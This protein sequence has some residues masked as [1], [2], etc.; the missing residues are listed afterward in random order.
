MKKLSAFTLIE[1][2]V[3][4]AIIAILA[5]MLLPILARAREEA[6]RGTCSNN[7]SQI[8]K[9]MMAYMNLYSD[10]WTFQ[11]DGRNVNIGTSGSPKYVALNA[12]DTEDELHN[13]CVS[14]SLLYNRWIEDTNVFRCSSAEEVPIIVKES[15]AHSSWSGKAPAIYSWFGK[16]DSLLIGDGKKGT[17]LTGYYPQIDGV[18]EKG[19]GAW[20]SGGMG[21]F[22]LPLPPLTTPPTYWNHGQ[23]FKANDTVVI[24]TGTIQ[25]PANVEYRD[26]ATAQEDADGRLGKANTSYAYDDRGNMRDMLP[27]S[28]RMSDARYHVPGSPGTVNEVSN[29]GKDGQNVLYW[30]G[31]VKFADSPYCSSDPQ[32]N[33]FKADLTATQG[34]G[35]DATLA[36]THMDMLQPNRAPLTENQLNWTNW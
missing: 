15:L 7:M 5:G 34:S 36:R 35:K 29:H 25:A 1:L 2:L 26:F 4:I 28:A 23:F 13:P 10:M 24:P 22:T 32:D 8:G 33:V 18:G 3:V 21:D 27:G 31:H 11:E 19:A 20:P 16:E 17:T 30:D 14:L 12:Q 9:S 6:R